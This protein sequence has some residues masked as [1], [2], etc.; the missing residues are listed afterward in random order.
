MDEVD[1]AQLPD[2]VAN[3]VLAAAADKQASMAFEIIAAEWRTWPDG[4]LG[5]G[6]PGEICTQAQVPGWEVQLEAEET[7]YAYR[8][9]DTGQQVRLAR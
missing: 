5:L 3:A 1:T 8:T 7:R 4:C 6:N 9:D 2:A